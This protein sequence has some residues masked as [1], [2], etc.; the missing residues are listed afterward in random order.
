MKVYSLWNT[1]IIHLFGLPPNYMNQPNEYT[2]K[3]KPNTRVRTIY[4]DG[5]VINYEDK[6]DTNKYKVKLAYGYTIIHRDDIQDLDLLD[7]KQKEFDNSTLKYRQPNVL[8]H[9]LTLY[10]N[11]YIYCFF[12][13]YQML[14]DRLLQ[15]KEVSKNRK[16]DENSRSIFY[17][18]Y[19]YL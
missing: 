5:I 14:Y 9:S 12:R 1:M 19:N 13:L 15:V 3:L 7:I 4:G 8:N 2:S 17:L 6:D 16:V 11:M 18:I 10:C